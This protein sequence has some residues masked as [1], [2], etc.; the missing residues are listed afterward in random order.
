MRKSEERA[1]QLKKEG[2]GSCVCADGK[3]CAGAGKIEK[4]GKET[5]LHCGLHTVVEEGKQKAALM[6]QEQAQACTRKRS[7]KTPFI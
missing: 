4:K 5:F 1:K 6:T 2:F 3:A 7:H